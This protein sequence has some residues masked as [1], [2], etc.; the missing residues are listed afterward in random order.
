MGELPFLVLIPLL[1][2][3]RG[4]KSRIE[5]LKRV[6]SVAEVGSDS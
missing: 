5:R 2:D 3:D 1:E 4:V 6:M